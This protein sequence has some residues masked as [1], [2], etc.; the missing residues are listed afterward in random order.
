MSKKFPTDEFD[1]L[2]P[3]GGRHRARRTKR[4]RA[5]EFSRIL[6]VAAITGAIGLVGLRILDS[7]VEFNGAAL[8]SASST[9]QVV[10]VGVTVLDTT[11]TDGLASSTAQKLIDAGWNVLTADNLDDALAPDKSVIFIA[12]EENRS[13]AKKIMKTLGNFSIDIS[14]SYSDP[15]TVILGSDFK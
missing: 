13:A 4:D 7:G 15:I 11:G 3:R 2:E 8:P 10:S 1:F 6:V 12:S 14:T 9:A 5:R